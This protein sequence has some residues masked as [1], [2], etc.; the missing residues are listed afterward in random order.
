MI[1]RGL[2]VRAGPGRP[3]RGV[4]NPHHD[5]VDVVFCFVLPVPLS[6]GFSKSGASCFSPVPM[7]NRSVV[8]SPWNVENRKLSHRGPDTEVG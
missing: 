4:G 3:Q 7:A 6:F 8:V 1:G 2:I 5:L